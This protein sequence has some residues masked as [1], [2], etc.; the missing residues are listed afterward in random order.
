MILLFHLV[1]HKNASSFNFKQF[2]S[3][4]LPHGNKVLQEYKVHPLFTRTPAFFFL[5]FFFYI[6]LFL[7]FRKELY[8]K[9]IYCEISSEVP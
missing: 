6:K 4:I 3:P 1:S 9:K 7:F 5:F 8:T 2:L